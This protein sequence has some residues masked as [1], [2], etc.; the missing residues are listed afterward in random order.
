MIVRI[1][2]DR[3]R[4]TACGVDRAFVGTRSRERFNW[5]SATTGTFS[6][7]QW[8]SASGRFLQFQRTV[9]GK[10]RYAH[11]LQVSIAISLMPPCLRAYGVRERLRWR[12]PGRTHRY[13]YIAFF[14]QNT[15][16]CRKCPVF[17]IE[18][19]GTDFSLAT[20]RATPENASYRSDGIPAKR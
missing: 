11:Q 2:L 6:F 18:L 17:I 14:E 13:R 7:R 5:D 9:I 20:A 8:L 12:Q 15:M 1:P 3:A 10:R 19:P 4:S 16:R